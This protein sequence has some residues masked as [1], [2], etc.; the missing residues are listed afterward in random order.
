MCVTRLPLSRIKVVAVLILALVCV[1]V[2]LAER[3]MQMQPTVLPVSFSPALPPVQ[4]VSCLWPIHA[5]K[6][7]PT[8]C[9]MQRPPMV[10]LSLWPEMM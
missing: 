8:M 5:L 4:S 9:L 2:S 3:L 10:A 1:N 6:M 7:Q